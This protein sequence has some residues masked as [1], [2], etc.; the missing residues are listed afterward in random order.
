[1]RKAQA[2][3]ILALSL[4]VARPS[5]ATEICG[6]SID[7][8]S[9]GSTDEGCAPTLTTDVCE[10]PLSCMETGMVSW[11]TGSLHYDLAPDVAPK[12]P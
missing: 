4:L 2:I 3:A 7:D 1:M 12:V 5:W 6:N 11:S 10:S 8:D 9:N